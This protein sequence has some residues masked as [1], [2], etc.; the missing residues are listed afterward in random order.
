M[1]LSKLL[2]D[3]KKKKGLRVCGASALSRAYVLSLEMRLYPL[4]VGGV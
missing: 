3:V 2:P 4:R 1:G